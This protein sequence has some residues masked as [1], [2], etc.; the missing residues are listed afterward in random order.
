MRAGHL[1]SIET[2]E[3]TSVVTTAPPFPR[4]KIIKESLR[5][6]TQTAF[7]RIFSVMLALLPVIALSTRGILGAS[8]GLLV[9]FTILTVVL[10]RYYS[11]PLGSLLAIPKQGETETE[12]N[13]NRRIVRNKSLFAQ[14]IR[15]N[16][17]AS[18]FVGG[19][20]V[21]APSFFR[22]I[23]Q[24]EESVD[25]ASQ[26]LRWSWFGSMLQLFA[27]MY[28][29]TIYS[30]AKNGERRRWYQH[31]YGREML[32]I[33]VNA[34]ALLTDFLLIRAVSNDISHKDY[35]KRM[36]QIYSVGFLFSTIVY[37]L[38]FKIRDPFHGAPRIRFC[39]LF[40]FDHEAW[41]EIR[42]IAHFIALMIGIETFFPNL[43]FFF[44]KLYGK[45]TQALYNLNTLFFTTHLVTN[46]GL[47][48]GGIT[49]VVKNAYLQS[50]L[51]EREARRRAGRRARITFGVNAAINFTLLTLPIL[52]RPEML[53]NLLT[54]DSALATELSGTLPYTAFWGLLIG[55]ANA[56]AKGLL[57]VQYVRFPAMVKFITMWVVG[58]SE[59]AYI[60]YGR[61][62]DHKSSDKQ[63]VV[64]WFIGAN[65]IVASIQAL[66]LTHRM[67][68]MH[69]LPPPPR[70][71]FQHLS[72]TALST[73]VITVAH[74]PTPTAVVVDNAAAT[75]E[76]KHN[77]QEGDKEDDLSVTTETDELFSVRL[78]V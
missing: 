2:T 46:L 56:G 3:L 78:T 4:S 24:D 64:K 35:A 14:T 59:D 6:G 50:D 73:T 76:A 30:L 75:V 53:A 69:R 49:T 1:A 15:F 34:S 52:M 42:K 5:L 74:P 9:Q 20:F 58:T 38:I 33:F 37:S 7:T 51:T 77:P 32:P 29:V 19:I 44:I 27:R 10:L 36:G 41:N 48:Q 55:V 60:A 65:C 43:E 13:K 16:L 31:L 67:W 18:L 8:S 70:C 26:F 11:L 62:K 72:E 57:G 22:L 45:E 25:V 71:R 17:R 54:N 21:I 12:A 39:D 47:M 23:G 61:F 66:A 68:K 63:T 40:C 28:E